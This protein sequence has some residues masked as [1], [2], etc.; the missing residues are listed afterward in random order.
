G[1]SL[2]ESGSATVFVLSALMSLNDRCADDRS[3]IDG[4]GPGDLDYG[5]RVIVDFVHDG[6]QAG[7]S[8]VARLPCGE[9]GRCRHGVA[10]IKCLL[11]LIYLN[12]RRYVSGTALDCRSRRERIAG[13]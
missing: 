7:G 11:V 9:Q 10:V 1:N 5:T 13:N 8:P 2:L 12:I 4:V 3:A 6:N